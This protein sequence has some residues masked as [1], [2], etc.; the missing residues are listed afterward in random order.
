MYKEETLNDL[1]NT[2]YGSDRVSLFLVIEAYDKYCNT[3]TIEYTGFN[4]NSGYVYISLENSISIVSCFGQEVEFLVTDYETVEE[5]FLD[6]Y[7]DAM[8]KLNE[9]LETNQ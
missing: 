3:E 5:H 2:L 9:I 7:D 4:R 1:L 8:N 6:S